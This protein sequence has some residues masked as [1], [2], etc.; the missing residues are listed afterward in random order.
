MVP[1]T[2]SFSVVLLLFPP[3]ICTVCMIFV[4]LVTLTTYPSASIEPS[5][6]QERDMVEIV[7]LVTLKL[8]GIDDGTKNFEIK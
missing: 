2:R 5:A 6:F 4:P 7:P 1:G 8:D 3:S